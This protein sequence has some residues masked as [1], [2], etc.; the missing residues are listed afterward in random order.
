MNIRSI[1]VLLSLLVAAPAPAADIFVNNLAGHDAANGQAAA[2]S[3]PQSGPVRTIARALSLAAAG[4]RIVL[5]KTEE[6]YREAVSLSGPRNSGD[7]NDPLTIVGNGATLDGTA[8]VPVRAWEHFQGDVFRFKPR[9]KD[10][11]MLYRDGRPL[12]QVRVAKGVEKLPTLKPLQWCLLGGHVYLRMEKLK[13][14]LD[15]KLSHS[16][17][18]TGVTLYG[19]RRVLISDLIVQGFRYDGIR[20]ADRAAA[21]RLSGVTLRGNGRSGLSVT[22]ASQVWLSDSLV[23]DNGQAQVRVEYPGEVNIEKCD[24]LDNT[25]PKL[26]KLNGGRVH[27]SE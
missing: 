10:Y 21:V 26:E 25:A 6:P 9:D 22:G 27:I 13:H 17:L 23:G 7:V 15:Y 11:Q 3:S 1:L 2:G 20:S 18:P 8:E 16:V 19:V 4:D 5:E 24:L 12:A 14:P